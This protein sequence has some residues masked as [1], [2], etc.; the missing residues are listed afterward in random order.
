VSS[1]ES[2][3]RVVAIRVLAALL[4]VVIV[5][6]LYLANRWSF[7]VPH[8]A[9]RQLTHD[10]S[11]EGLPSLSPDGG[12]IAYRS[13]AAGNGDILLTR[14]DGQ[15][16]VNLTSSSSDDESDPAF[17]PDGRQ[18]AFRS[19][20]GGISLVPR[21]GGAIRQLTRE[22]VNPA[23][24]PDGRFIVYAG[25]RAINDI[26]AGATE[27][28][29]VDIITGATT[30][31]AG[32]GDFHEPAVSPHNRRVAYWGRPI[33]RFTR[34]VVG[35]R[36]HLWTAL[37]D[38]GDAHRVTDD[39]ASETSPLW[40]PDGRYLYYISGRGGQSAIWRVR[41]DE[42]TG[43]AQGQPVAVPT[44]YSQP[45]RVTRSADGRR[46][47]W[48]DAA[49]IQRAMR[50]VLD[51]DARITRG[52]A[53]EIDADDSSWESAE[54]SPDGT[55]FVL[56]SPRGHLHLATAEGG[57][58]RLLTEDQVLDRHPRWSPDGRWIAFQS[59][60]GGSYSVWLVRADGQG[61]R[62]LPRGTGD[63]LYPVWS[64]D[65]DQL[66]VWD[67]AIAGG[68][69]VRVGDEAMLAE[70]LPSTAQGGFVPSDWSPDG[71]VIAGTVA[72]SVWLYSVDGH[73]YT[74]LKPGTNPAWLSDSRRLVYAY[75]G[76]LYIADTVLKI[77]RELL[78]IPDQQLD[79]PRVSGDNRELYFSESGTD[80]N[81]WVMT[82][83]PS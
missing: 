64:P 73:S 25:G 39:A 45:V 6:S 57:R 18:I 42:R 62:E 27:G 65:G 44:P 55:K 35:N 77:S 68:R 38:G 82:V 1:H 54:P 31:L 72:G 79:S 16:T 26:R 21:S 8:G 43:H 9:I 59:N 70:S 33:D 83:S 5:G 23:W 78:S 49:P 19:A 51:T 22:G 75:G 74:Q 11:F 29:K 17:S 12:W 37:L 61:L 2:R 81:L 53:I 71:R 24:S 67:T 28:W 4:P 60:R 47:A 41:I 56:M 13:D 50:I 30:R 20:R 80:A 10:R 63:L 36:G 69:I 58:P 15:Q 76:D 52:P 40:S 34:R 46:F 32:V 3:F 7:R 66:V 14:V 48:S